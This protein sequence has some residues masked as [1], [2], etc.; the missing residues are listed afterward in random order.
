MASQLR[1][2]TGS[3]QAKP[4]VYYVKVC[5]ELRGAKLRKIAP[6]RTATC[7]DVKATETNL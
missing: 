3:K 5:N 2:I 4:L 1:Y 6:S 7:V